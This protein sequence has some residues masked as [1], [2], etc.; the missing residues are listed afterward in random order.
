MLCTDI[1]FQRKL[2]YK[3]I[4]L[5]LGLAGRMAP[6][7]SPIWEYFGDDPDNYTN[8]ICK[9]PNCPKPRVSRGPDNSSKSNL[10]V[11]VL[12]NHLKNHHPREYKDHLLTVKAKE[13]DKKRKSNDDEEANEME[14][15]SLADK[16]AKGDTQTTL[17]GWMQGVS[18]GSSSSVYPFNDP[19]A[20]ARHRHR[21]LQPQRGCFHL[22]ATLLM[23]VPGFCLRI[24][25][26]FY[27]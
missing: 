5:G 23:D 12:N 7:T 11:S 24:L 25:R 6:K 22:L 14:H 15:N 17:S 20:K 21:L 1:V 8:A 9:V 26:D 18:S 10:S 3:I 16:R 13:N 4:T 2:L 27:S 19:R